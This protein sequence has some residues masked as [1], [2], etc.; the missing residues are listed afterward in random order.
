MFRER[1][2]LYRDVFLGTH[3][4]DWLIEVGLAADRPDAVCYGQRLLQ[5]RV[6]EH[7]MRKHNF[8]DLPYFYHF[9]EES[10]NRVYY[11]EMP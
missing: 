3:L 1:L 10:H 11:D 6:L 5:G 4:V 7:I 9:T 8:Q 2:R